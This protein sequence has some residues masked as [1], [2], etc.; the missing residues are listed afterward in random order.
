MPGAITIAV[1][2]ITDAAVVKRLLK[3]ANLE[4]G[5]EYVKNGKGALDQNLAGYNNAARF[6]CWLVLRDLD[7][8]ASC[9]P[10]LRHKMLFAPATHMRF[11]V[12]VRAVEA[13]LLADAESFGQFFSLPPSRIPAEPESVRDPKHVLVN[14]VRQ[15]RKKAV[16]EAL[17]PPLGVSAKVGP[18][19]AALLIQFITQQWRPG[20]AARRSPSLARLRT[21]L[22]MVPQRNATMCR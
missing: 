11:H 22:R 9:A 7:H 14:L 15:S 20:L 19:Y 8:D 1:E 16:R 21:F 5:H 3:E 10:Q 2:G 6:S 17:S 12:S 18:G 13:W 4:L